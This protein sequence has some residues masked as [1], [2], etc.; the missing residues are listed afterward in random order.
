MDHVSSRGVPAEEFD[1]LR[2][3]YVAGEDGLGARSVHR[4]AGDAVGPVLVVGDGTPQHISVGAVVVGDQRE[5]EPDRHENHSGGGT[6]SFVP[7][8]AVA[9]LAPLLAG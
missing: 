5:R 3:V 6:G 1:R 8:D 9:G 2:F 7:P 4:R